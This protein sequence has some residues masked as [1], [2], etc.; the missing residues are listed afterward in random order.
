MEQET[1][2]K[3]VRQRRVF[4]VILT[5]LSILLAVLPIVV[6][7]NGTLTKV[8]EATS[9]YRFVQIYIVPYEVKI[10]A[11]VLYLVHIPSQIQTDGL[12]VNGTFLQVT[13]NCLG[14]QSLLFL[15]ISLGVGLGTRYK[16]WSIVET[17]M[18]GIAGTFLMNVLRMLTI[19]LLGAFARPI[20]ALVFHDYLA[21]FLTVSWLLLFWWFSYGFVLEEKE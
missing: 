15:C 11:A 19:V 1:E 7:L 21:A 8:V 14:W 17:V 16:L 3:T 6:A 10:V 9:W 12:N 4:E 5:G 13:W 2:E 20:F 18:I